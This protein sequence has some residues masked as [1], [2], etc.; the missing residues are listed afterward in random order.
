MKNLDLH[1]QAPDQSSTALL[2]VD[3]INDLEFVGGEAL[4]RHAVPMAQRIAILKRQVK[5]IGVPVIYANDNFGKW[6]SDFNNLVRHVRDNN[7][8]GR[9]LVELLEPEED[10]YCVL[11]PKHSG[12]FHTTLD[13]LLR[14]LQVTTLI[15][16]GIQTHICVLFTANDAYIRDFELIIPSDC[17]AAEQREDH[18]YALRLMHQVLKADLRP[19][20]D[21]S[22]KT[23]LHTERMSS[24][25]IPG[26]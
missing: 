13:L 5:S 22:V 25:I 21:W 18:E 26:R 1:G 15:I 9:P 12:F 8:R 7:H 3:V 2:I 24:A 4:L 23:L 17:V 14:Y 11:K 19:S 10:D 20:T 16:T 6:R